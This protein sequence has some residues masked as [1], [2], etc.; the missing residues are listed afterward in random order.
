MFQGEKIPQEPYLEVDPFRAQNTKKWWL[1]ESMLLSGLA[2]KLPPSLVRHRLP[3]PFDYF[4]HAGN[5]TWSL[6]IGGYVSYAVQQELC[7]R[8]QTEG[9]NIRRLGVIAGSLA[10]AAANIITETK[11]GGSVFREVHGADPID[12]LYGIPAGIWGSNLISLRNQRS[13]QATD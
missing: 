8:S 3:E 7:K 1:T 6:L 4:N 11:Y 2:S 9:G 5:F 12:A 10:A 13:Q